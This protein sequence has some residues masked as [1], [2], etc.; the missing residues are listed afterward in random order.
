MA[1]KTRWGMAEIYSLTLPRLWRI[2][3]G[4][5]KLNAAQSGEAA[6]VDA[7]DAPAA[8]FHSLGGY[9][10]ERPFDCLPLHIQAWSLRCRGLENGQ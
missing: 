2:M 3:D 10:S 9:A 1:E 5:R 7:A 8:M 6:D 4:F